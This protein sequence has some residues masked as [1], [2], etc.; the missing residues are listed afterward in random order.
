MDLIKQLTIVICTLVLLEFTQSLVLEGVSENRKINVIGH[1]FG[2]NNDSYLEQRNNILTAESKESVGGG[3][4]LA[5]LEAQVNSRLLKL[6]QAEIDKAH[7]NKTVLP[8]QINFL[9][10]APLYES[11]E[12]FQMIKQMPKG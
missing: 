12:V 9:L 10:A 1:R 8:P 4:T 2:V 5:P 3:I 11:S 6:K 7:Y